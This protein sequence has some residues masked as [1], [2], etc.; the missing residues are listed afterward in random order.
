MAC[1]P[2]HIEAAIKK[3]NKSLNGIRRI[4]F[5]ISREARVIIYKALVLPILEYGNVL[6]DNCAI[7]TWNRDMRVY[8][9][10]QQWFV[11]VALETQV[12]ISSFMNWVRPDLK[13]EENV[14]DFVQILKIS[15]IQS[16]I[17][18]LTW[19]D[20]WAPMCRHFQSASVWNRNHFGNFTSM[21]KSVVPLAKWL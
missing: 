5:L 18:A 20:Y 19:I 4:R 12:T 11:H 3:A 21:G 7:F 17:R 1:I 8:R 9:D 13:R 2:L 6:Y 14:S 15:T 16:D 10:R